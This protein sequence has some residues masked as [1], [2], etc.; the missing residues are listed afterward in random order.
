MSD[1]M[2]NATTER[3]ISTRGEQTNTSSLS[4]SY[5]RLTLFAVFLP[6]LPTLWLDIDTFTVMWLQYFP[7]QTG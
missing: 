5:L 6:L 4:P 3:E 2:V 1:R 7:A